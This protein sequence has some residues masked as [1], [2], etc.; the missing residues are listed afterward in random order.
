MADLTPQLR[1]QIIDALLALP[2]SN[3]RQA[4]DQWLLGLPPQLVTLIERSDVARVDIGEIVSTVTQW[5]RD[6]LDQLLAGAAAWAP[7][8]EPGDRVAA[9]RRRLHQR[10]VF[11]SYK[12]DVLPDQ[13][14]VAQI[15]SALSQDQAVFIDQTILV[16]TA[17]AERIEQ[18]LRQADY[19]IVFLS[20]QAVQSEMLLAEV[21]TAATHFAMDHKPL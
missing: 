13:P 1:Q 12:R 3:N 14:L 16:G 19:L 5:S 9:L 8:S 21:A 4:R 20:A 10:R 7:G 2:G 11:L 17:W 18:E 6:A 15:Y